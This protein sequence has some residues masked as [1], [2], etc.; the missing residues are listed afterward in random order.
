MFLNYGNQNF[1]YALFPVGL[2]KPLMKADI[3]H[4]VVDNWPDPALLK[5]MP[6]LGNKFAL[7][8]KFHSDEQHENVKSNPL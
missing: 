4:Q 1:R 6:G 2:A 8:Q 3:Y 5:S 7:S